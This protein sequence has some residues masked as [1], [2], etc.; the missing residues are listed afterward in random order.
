M[1]LR[2]TH[3][4]IWGLCMSFL[5]LLP[6]CNTQE[7][8]E[9][10]GEP[11]TSEPAQFTLLSSEETGIDFQN[12]LNEGLNT[13]ILV[14]EY[15][16]NGGGVATGDLNGDGLIDIYF[17]SNMGANKLY[18]NE[19]GMKFKDI[20][21]ASGTMGRPGPWK[22]G[23]S[24]VDVN[25]DGKLDI[26]LCYS[27]ALP[28][29]KRSNQLFMNTGNGE[30][31][32]PL[33]Q[34]SAAQY[35]LASSAFSNQGYF[36][37]YDRDGD[38]DMLLLNHNPKSIPVLNVQQSAEFLRI[39]DPQRGLRL[40]RQTDAYFE[41]VTTKSGI[42]GSALSYGLGLGIADVDQDGWP[43]FYL[44]NDYTVPD[45]LY[46]NQKDGTFRNELNEQMG[47]NS[48]F[49]MGNDIADINNDGLQDIFTLDMLPEDNHR[50]KLLLS[51]D[52]YAKFDLNVRSGFHYQYMRNMLQLNN[53]DG[54][55]SE[56]GQ[57]SGISNTDWSWAALLA[58]YDN[59]GWKDLFVSNGYNRDYT[60]LDFIKYMEDFVK[61]KGR[62]QREDVLEIIANMP[63]SDVSNYIFVN[64]QGRTFKDKTTSWGMDQVA[65]SNGA[66]YADLDNDGDLDLVINNVN[67]AAFI[68]QNEAQNNS[69]NNYLQLALKGKGLNSQGIGASVQIFAGGEQQSLMQMPTRGYLSSV[70]PVLHL[71]LGSKSKVDSLVIQWPNGKTEV[72]TGIP[73]NQQII[74]EEEVAQMTLNPMGFPQTLFEKVDS[75]IEYESPPLNISDFDRQ[76]LLIYEPSY[77]GP[78]MAKGD[79]N[80]DGL[81]DVLIT[82]ASQQAVSLYIQQT[83]NTF[84]AQPVPAFETDARAQDTDIK[85]LDANGDGFLDVYVAS[86]GYH[87]FSSIDPLLQD[88]LYL[89]DGQG[90]FTRSPD[91]L[92]AMQTG[93]GAVAISDV[94]GDGA[95]DI[96]V[97]GK[98]NP[99]RYPEAAASYL[100]INDGKGKFSDE[101]NQL[102]P[103]L[104]KTG[105]ITD[106]EWADLNT[107]GNV[108]LI[109]LGDWMPVSVY[110]KIDGKLVN[111]SSDYFR[112]DYTGWWNNILVKDLNQDQK[113]DLL[114]GNI[115]TNTQFEV[116]DSEPA[117]LYYKDFD[118][119]GALDPIFCYYIQG[120]SYP[121]L[122][123]DELLGQ[124]TQLRKRYTSFASYADATVEEIFDTNELDDSP[125][126]IANHMKTSL[127][128]MGADGKFEEK[129]LPLEAQY[130]PV[131][132][133]TS[134]DYDGDG[135]ED[136][137]LCGNN[138]HM[139]LRLGKFDANYGT[140]L[141]GDGEGNFSY[142]PQTQSGFQI[143]G[144]V[145]S[146]L[147]IDQ[148][149][150]FGI[151]EGTLISY[152]LAQ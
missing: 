67:K 84:R 125:K 71:G 34:E 80:G 21:L 144:D 1:L 38:L 151:N 100:L 57:L 53:G 87:S 14:Y 63:A 68:Y 46:I 109:I 28:E 58:D 146:V 33:F 147:Q 19:G 72:R 119:N 102:A 51:P 133:A 8:S 31:D 86:G 10:S 128:L 115:G 94:N 3:Y 111:K 91:A 98:I 101:I 142:V 24:M 116:S 54:S 131:Y 70:S 60:N 61:S 81:E 50:Q 23:V 120:K 89:N 66:A 127:F 106:V 52:N 32:I 11:K 59:D 117:E 6:S 55:F 96:F 12:T 95:P 48:H 143:K 97:G 126:W 99:G 47:H 41:D 65:N 138:Q 20:T 45:Y 5:F 104:Q 122:T 85:L 49:S 124:L 75:P 17:T 25:G 152:K 26:Y 73:A 79:V 15:F 83:N 141:K 107:D 149:L 13:N 74:L 76:A 16:Y 22:T 139:K 39:D 103:D 43:D 108:E 118:G 134:L 62:L 37:D 7:A 42:N 136:L 88:R 121:Y 92:P 44:S 113:P 93:T 64:D 132:T 35:G 130:S 148:H 27:G 78:V 82:G 150:L 114:L 145:R 140:L 135:R 30:A 105:M 56:I 123:R 69:K 29:H 90:N 4:C 2:Y 36:F 77:S 110:E 9:A 137:L 129:S 112:K 40:F 18:L